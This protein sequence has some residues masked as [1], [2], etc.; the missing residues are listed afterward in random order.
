MTSNVPERAGAPR[1]IRGVPHALPEGETLL[2]E[3]APVWRAVWRHVFFG[4]VFSAYFVGVVVWWMW[5]TAAPFGSAEFW[6]GALLASMASA[7]AIGITVML[8]VVVARTSWYAITSARVVMRVGM[9]FPMSI[10]VPFTIV[11]SAGVGQFGDGTGQ[12]QLQLSRRQRIAYIALWP[13][14][15]GFAFGAPQPVLRGLTE[16]QRV[17]GLLAEAV[18]AHAART[19]EAFVGAERTVLAGEPTGA[20]AAVVPTPQAA[21]A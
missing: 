10:N 4:R 20:R 15:K 21:G 18:S 17:G 9:V 2:W 13:H 11:E 8:S 16:P 7:L 12:L 3:G 1:F 6:S 14:C 19:G 5:S